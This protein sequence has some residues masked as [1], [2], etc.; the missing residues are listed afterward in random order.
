MRRPASFLQRPSSLE[1]AVS[2]SIASQRGRSASTTLRNTSSR[3]SA[4]L[5]GTTV[6]TATT[7]TTPTTM[8]TTDQAMTIRTAVARLTNRH[9][10]FL[11]VD[12]TQSTTVAAAAA[13]TPMAAIA[14]AEIKA[15]TSSSSFHETGSECYYAQQHL[16]PSG[17]LRDTQRHLRCSS[18]P[19]QQ[20][21]IED[22]SSAPEG[23]HTITLARDAIPKSLV[24]SDLTSVQTSVDHQ[25]HPKDGHPTKTKTTDA[26]PDWL[27]VLLKSRQRV[28]VCKTNSTATRKTK[29]AKSTADG[30]LQAWDVGRATS[31]APMFFSG[32]KLD[33]PKS[34]HVDGDPEPGVPPLSSTLGSGSRSIPP[35]SASS[36]E[37][38]VTFVT[39]HQSI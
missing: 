3:A 35:L 2:A 30:S 28:M 34:T 39:R 36:P 4:C 1:S 32:K 37:S 18:E 12:R 23:D 14:A 13:A 7:Q 8:M 16:K 6:T 25:K 11:E 19:I 33:I 15:A 17:D 5:T 26:G 31:A 27:D 21:S 22:R 29:N 20:R 9:R 24:Q 10:A 38:K